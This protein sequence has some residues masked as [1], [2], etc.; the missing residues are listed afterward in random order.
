M[1][2][3]AIDIGGTN[4]RFALV[5]QSGALSHH[6]A[7]LCADFDRIEDAFLAYVAIVDQQITDATICVAGPVKDD[8]VKVTNNHWQFSKAEMRRHLGLHSLLVVNDFTAQALA[9]A[10]PSAHG[11]VLLLDGSSQSDKPLLVIGPGTGL[12]VSALIPTARGVV[13]IEGEGGHVGLAPQTDADLALHAALQQELPYVSVEDVISGRG[14]ERLYRYLSGGIEKP[15]PQIGEAA[16]AAAGTDRDAAQ[17]MLGLLGTVIA[18]HALTLGCWRG[19]VIAGGIVA[20]LQ[21]L[22]ETS[23]FAARLRHDGLMAHLLADLPVWLSVDPHAGLRGAAAAF[24][25]E[26]LNGRRI[27]A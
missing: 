16:I 10:D 25:N 27:T 11:N 4:A 17:M 8:D 14:L 2:L 1:T 20:Q 12:G 6:H 19:V 5:D 21:P 7:L 15:A 18:D 24:Q 26:N 23:P 3:V 13:P 9:Q 22:I